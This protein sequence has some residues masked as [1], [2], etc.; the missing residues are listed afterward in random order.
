MLVS[1]GVVTESYDMLDGLR[2]TPLIVY[3][4]GAHQLLGR[5]HVAEHH[6]NSRIDEL[7]SHALV[8]RRGHHCDSAHVTLDQLAQDGF[9]PSLVVLGVAKKDVEPAILSRSLESAND[10]GEVRVCDL[11]NHQPEQIAAARGLPPRMSI[12]V[13]FQLPD[14]F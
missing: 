10:F 7:R 12:L 5:A 2:D 11:R 13:L 3:R 1:G 8:D 6:A 14:D 4:N 9:R